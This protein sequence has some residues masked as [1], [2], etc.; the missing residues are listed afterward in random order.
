MKRSEVPVKETWDLS[1]I[2]KTADDAWK[3]VDEMKKNGR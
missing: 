2:Y 1:L 3:A